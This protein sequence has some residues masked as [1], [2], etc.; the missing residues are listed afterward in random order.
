MELACPSCGTRFRLPDGA[1]GVPGR[2]RGRTVRCGNCGH[3]WRAGPEDALAPAEAQATAAGAR[4]AEPVKPAAA[5]PPA[6]AAREPLDRSAAD[7]PIF[8]GAGL[9]DG[10]GDF[11]ARPGELPGDTY[12]HD[13]VPGPRRH[14]PAAPPARPDGPRWGL[15]LG[16]LLFV[17]IAVGLV[18]GGWHFRERIV[19]E[20][21]ET[22][23]L[24]D[25]LGVP[26]GAAGPPFVLDWKR[27][28]QTT[29]T[30]PTVTLSGQV[31]NASE[32]AVPAPQLVVVL[33]N[34]AGEQIDS[35]AVEVP[36]GPLAT[37]EARDFSTR[38]PWPAAAADVTV[39]PLR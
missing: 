39:R 30:G 32:E 27:A 13:E 1:L 31:I 36:G 6:R 28:I 11:G 35:W 8:G 20:V 2:S 21:P 14:R 33:L 25:L 34:Q 10:H 23:R 7:D 38:G 9:D 16:W 12:P 26:V 15:A 29:E 18:A 24:Y 22:Q 19:A 4:A 37:G 3:G 5:E 17:L